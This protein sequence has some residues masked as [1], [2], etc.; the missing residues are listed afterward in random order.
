VDPVLF[1]PAGSKD[2]PSPAGERRH[3]YDET[4]ILVVALRREADAGS[5]VHLDE[6][7]ALLESGRERP[8]DG[9]RVAGGDRPGRDI[10][11][12]GVGGPGEREGGEEREGEKSHGSFSSL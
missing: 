6:E 9:D 5:P 3:L 2:E 11:K 1:D 7:L 8:R 12:A 4:G 10:E